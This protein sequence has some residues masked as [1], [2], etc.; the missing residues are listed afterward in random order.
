[1]TRHSP[2]V[3]P[4]D[5]TQVAINMSQPQAAAHYGLSVWQVI[6]MM[7][8]MTPEWRDEYRKGWRVRTAKSATRNL[9]RYRAQFAA[10]KAPG[11]KRKG[12][13]PQTRPMP[14]GFY[15]FILHNSQDAA[16]KEYR[17]SEK[18][19]QRWKALLDPEQRKAV[20]A[21]IKER[22]AERMSRLH[23]GRNRFNSAKP[24]SD[25]TPA[26]KPRGRGFGFNKLPDVAPLT[27]SI[28]AMAAQHLR[29]VERHVAP[30]C[31]ATV[32]LGKAGDGFYKYGCKL[33]PEAFIVERAKATGWAGA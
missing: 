32:V 17:T 22:H 21:G 4:A 5:F 1:M 30:I 25:K 29:I 31:A 23:S 24:K 28:V 20:T 13:G 11:D 33:V 3:M 26:K 6:R 9:N 7:R 18:T 15:E 8:Q 12:P 16:C 10:N 27:G 14:E 2:A 19:V